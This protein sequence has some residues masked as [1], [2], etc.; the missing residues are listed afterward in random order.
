[1]V[2]FYFSATNHMGSRPW[3]G[4]RCLS[5]RRCHSRIYYAPDG[6]VVYCHCSGEPEAQY[7][8]GHTEV[9]NNNDC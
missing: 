7:T 9:T 4:E 5:C 1:M 2:F 8:I 6:H 3:Y